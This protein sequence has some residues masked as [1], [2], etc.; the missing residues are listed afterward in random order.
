MKNFIV[1]LACVLVSVLA[2]SKDKGRAFVYYYDQKNGLYDYFIKSEKGDWEEINVVKNQVKCR[3]KTVSEAPEQTILYDEDRDLYLRLTSTKC[4]SGKDKSNT[5]N[6]LYDGYWLAMNEGPSANAMLDKGEDIFIYE[7]KECRGFF[8]K[9]GKEWLEYNYKHGLLLNT[10][11]IVEEDDD[12]ITLKCNRGGYYIK[13]TNK[14][15]LYSASKE[16]PYN[17]IYCGR[18]TGKGLK[19]S[20]SKS[21]SLSHGKLFAYSQKG[22]RSDGYFGYYWQVAGDVWEEVRVSDDKVLYQYKLV[23][24]SAN[25]VILY[26]ENRSVYVRLTDEVSYWGNT[27]SDI[28]NKVY[29]GT[30]ISYDYGYSLVMLLEIDV[31]INIFMFEAASYSGYYLLSSS[32]YWVEYARYGGAPVNTYII[33]EEAPTYIILYC[34][35]CGRYVKVTEAAVYYADSRDGEYTKQADGKWSQGKV[36]NGT[37]THSRLSSNA[38]K[39]AAKPAATTSAPSADPLIALRSH[40]NDSLKKLMKLSA[41]TNKAI[42]DKKIDKKNLETVAADIAR[43]YLVTL[44]KNALKKFNGKAIKISAYDKQ[45]QCYT[46]IWNTDIF[47]VYVPAG[48]AESFKTNWSKMTF[49]DPD[50]FFDGNKFRLSYLKI[51]NPVLKKT[52]TYDGRNKQQATL[53]VG[54][55]NVNL[56][57]S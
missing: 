7:R 53:K 18:F 23:S 32:G 51:T 20:S 41:L 27:K 30:W 17:R 2:F 29:E 12:H 43:Q 14:C 28:T 49:S 9:R 50:L 57:N 47:N 1:T 45:K 54:D 48:E 39:S 56:P 8:A 44:K 36:Q 34:G 55:L 5:T 15:C 46:L 38:S 16:G 11:S 35:K 42:N 10:Y 3:F 6:W 22:K 52:Y 21:G 33:I 19:E 4:F 24:E 25:E 37:D 40:V 13:L 31:E 26:D